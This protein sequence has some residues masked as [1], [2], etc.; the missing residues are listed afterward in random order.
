MKSYSFQAELEI[1]GINPFV[2]VPPDILQKIFQ[3]SGREKS[4][5][6][7]CGQ[8]NEKTYQQNLMFFSIVVLTY[9]RQSPLKNMRFC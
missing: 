4:P 1:I 5:I 7:I 3:D 9:K 8:I 6:P 2:A